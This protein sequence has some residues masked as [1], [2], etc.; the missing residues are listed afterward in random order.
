MKMLQV[1]NACS[2][3]WC[4]SGGWSRGFVPCFIFSDIVSEIVF[5][6]WYST[7]LNNARKVIAGGPGCWN[8]FHDARLYQHSRDKAYANIYKDIPTLISI[9]SC[10]PAWAKLDVFRA[11]STHECAT[12]K[13]L[14]ISCLWELADEAQRAS[15]IIPRHLFGHKSYTYLMI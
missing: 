9:I 7:Y 8:E 2:P 13:F 14:K 6:P 1:S 11:C 12:M 15:H 4:L 5:W 10:F 3:H